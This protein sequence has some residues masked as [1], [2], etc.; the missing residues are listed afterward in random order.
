MQ[1]S[2]KAGQARACPATAKN[3]PAGILL[4]DK[5]RGRGIRKRAGYTGERDE[6]GARLR[7]NGEQNSRDG[8]CR[9]MDANDLRKLQAV[10]AA[11]AAR[12]AQ[13]HNTVE[14]VYRFE[15]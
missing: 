4:D 15:L 11:W 12:A 2:A 1:L 13:P 3:W 10:R 6:V 8:Q 14:A 5:F 7:F 9:A